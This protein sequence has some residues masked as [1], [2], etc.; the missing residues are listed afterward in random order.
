[1]AS[2][3]GK[4]RKTIERWETRKSYR[5]NLFPPMT[6]AMQ[7]MAYDIVGDSRSCKWH[8]RG[9]PQHVKS[10]AHY[11]LV[12][13]C[14]GARHKILGC[15]TICSEGRRDSG[16]CTLCDALMIHAHVYLISI[17]CTCSS[18]CKNRCRHLVNTMR[19]SCVI[20][21]RWVKILHAELCI[22]GFSTSADCP[23]LVFKVQLNPTILPLATVGLY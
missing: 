8:H 14:D 23:R 7:V 22:V 19:T 3:R 20:G 4:S 6:M 12:I 9:S 11:A 10:T 16:G 5:I 1:M 18:L 13:S 21:A 17:A 2:L 15:S